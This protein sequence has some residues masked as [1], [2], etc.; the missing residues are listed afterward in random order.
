MP[1]DTFFHYK[2]NKLHCEGVSLDAL[3]EKFGTPL[4]VTSKQHLLSQ[5]HRFEKAFAGLNH[6]TCYAVKANYNLAVIRTLVE[7]GSGI[8]VNS[9]GELYRALKAGASP[10]KIIMA[11]V[12]KTADEI[13]YALETKIL[14]IKAESVSELKLINAIAGK[15]KRKAP[16]GIRI[17]P[18]VTAETH[19]YITTGDDSKKFGI[20]E[21]LAEETLRLVKKLKHIQLTGLDMHIG[22]KIEDVS[23]YV[24]ATLKLL[25]IK[26]ITDTLGFEIDHIDIGGGFPIAYS[27]ADPDVPLEVFAKKLVPILKNVNAKIL[28]E[29]GR[30]IVGNASVL[31]TKVLYV[32]QNHKGKKFLIV[33]AAMTE[34]IR[35]TL[36]EA[37]HEILPVKKTGKSVVVDV[38][39]PVCESGDFFAHDRK[40]GEAKEGECIAVMSAGAYGSVMSSNYNA[41]LRP[42]EVMIDRNKILLTRK[43]ETLEQLVQNES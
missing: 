38:V 9:A 28:F 23:P 3:A 30:Y 18:N 22:S 42:A 1:T 43:R 7:A 5:Y 26:N 41:R 40:M 27:P 2:K 31:L 8:D 37:Y 36:Y 25:G 10:K 20:D 12:G 24:E 39:G 29:P 21:Q 16:V 13:R 17:N 6:L 32:K 11:G 35:P 15:L 19:P 4:F 34:L 33:D 14:M